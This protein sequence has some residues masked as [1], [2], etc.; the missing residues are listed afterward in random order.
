MGYALEQAFRAIKANWIATVST[1]TTMTLSL[2]ILAAF[3]LLSVN[4][5][6]ALTSM[7]NELEIAAYLVPH[8]DRGTLEAQ[9]S[10]WPEVESVSFVTPDE[11]LNTMLNELPSLAQAAA[12]VDNPL[13]PTLHVKL[14]HPVD[15][16]NIRARLEGLAVVTGID[17]SSEAESLFLALNDALRIG[18]MILVVVLLVATFVAIINA[19]RA[20][21][22]ARKKE[23]DVMRLVGASHAFIRAPFLIEGFL[24]GLVSA[25]LA[26]GI[27][28]PGYSA[29]ISRLAAEFTFVPFVRDAGLIAQITGLL[30]ALSML[31]GLG[32]SAVSVTQFLREE[33]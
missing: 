3:S 15:S 24:L 25:L 17:D 2:T 21:I 18:G 29:I 13:P 22:T 4:L 23:I 9:T 12:L 31:I 1:I 32:G 7:Q 6:A 27:T 5:N 16:A 33:Y 20:A 26:L 14:Y 11:A 8:V 28:I 10:A 19:I 30:A